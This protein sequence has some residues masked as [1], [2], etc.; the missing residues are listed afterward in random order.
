MYEDT[1]NKEYIDRWVEEMEDRYQYEK[2]KQ[3]RKGRL[4]GMEFKV[5][6]DVVIF[7]AGFPSEKSLIQG[8]TRAYINDNPNDTK[9]AL[10]PA[11]KERLRQV[12]S[13]LKHEIY[14]ARGYREEKRREHR[15]ELMNSAIDVVS[16]VYG[17]V[18]GLWATVRE[19]TP[20]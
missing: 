13:D 15:S 19:A 2:L 4:H 6:S 11:E 9:E 7:K 16:G 12:K 17:I 20:W 14:R 10:T 18:L 5:E 1:P 3:M 8:N